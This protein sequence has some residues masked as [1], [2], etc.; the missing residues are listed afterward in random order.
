MVKSDISVLAYGLV[1]ILI[2]VV[3]V[4]VVMLG[5]KCT[6]QHES[7]KGKKFVSKG[8][9]A[10]FN[11]AEDEYELTA[12]YAGS[13]VGVGCLK[14]EGGYSK[15]FKRTNKISCGNKGRYACQYLKYGED[16]ASLGCGCLEKMSKDDP[17]VIIP[18]KFLK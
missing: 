1:V 7:F 13:N 15:E 18:K 17:R 12:M 9:K 2:V 8:D 10:E 11:C 4:L 6:R 14:N 3:I 16:D 5:S